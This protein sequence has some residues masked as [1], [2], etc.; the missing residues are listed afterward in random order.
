MIVPLNLKSLLAQ[1]KP[2]K[3]N[4]F[5]D[6]F[7]FLHLHNQICWP[8]VLQPHPLDGWLVINWPS[9]PLGDGPACR[10]SLHKL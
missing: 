4:S 8:E 2:S 3:S 5:Q 6:E 1:E 7:P 9:L 10:S